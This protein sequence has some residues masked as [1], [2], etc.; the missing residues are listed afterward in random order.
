M[1]EDNMPFEVMDFEV[2][3]LSSQSGQDVMDAFQGVRM[4]VHKK[5]G[6]KV[7]KDKCVV[8]IALGGQVGPLG[9]DGEGKY[10][11]KVIWQDLNAAFTDAGKSETKYQSDWWQKNARFGFKTFL[12]ALGFDEKNP[13]R[14][15]DE[16][17]SNIAGKEFI[18]NITKKEIQ[19]QVDGKW[20]GTGEF[21]NELA[22]I[23]KAS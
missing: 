11:G 17:L 14:L 23:K 15:S 16:F 3:D 2:G 21:K 5:T 19:T 10:A 18:A 8:K 13:P 4:V 7:S 22:N 12:K 9:V 20:V 6:L 1:S